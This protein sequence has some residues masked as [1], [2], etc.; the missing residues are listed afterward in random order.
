MTC[1]DSEPGEPAAKKRQR[2]DGRNYSI[3]IPRPKAIAEY[4][5]NMGNVDMHNR[6]RQG[7]LRLHERWRTNT[8]QT[9]IQNELIAMTV[10]DAYLCAAKFMPKWRS[11]VAN[12]GCHD[13]SKLFDF[14]ADLCAT[15]K[16]LLSENDDVMREPEPVAQVCKQ[17]PIGKYEIKTG[18]N[19]GKFRQIQQRCRYCHLAGRCERLNAASGAKKGAFRTV[20]TCSVHCDVLMC[21]E[22][23]R[24]CWTEHLAACRVGER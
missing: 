3:D 16:T 24:A 13:T 21:R 11:A 22:G 6:Y 10:V 1:S 7:M 23:Q 15:M 17:V 2:A 9:R 12:Y 18:N 20:F 4:A 5:K 14:I 19:A 8:W